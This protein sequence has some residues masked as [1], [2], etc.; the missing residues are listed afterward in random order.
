MILPHLQSR[1]GSKLQTQVK[2]A[3]QVYEGKWVLKRDFGA[4]VRINNIQAQL[5]LLY[6]AD[7]TFFFFKQ[8]EG[9]WQPWVKQVYWRH[10]SKSI[11]SPCVSVSHFD[12]SSNI[13]NFFIIIIL[14]MVIC[15]CWS[16]MLLPRLAEGSDDSIFSNK[17]LLI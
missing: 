4:Q 8:I 7:I 16:L 13:S 6:F 14:V 12:N 17:E 5:I 15:D 10:F 2:R 11:C 9:L 1:V 3:S